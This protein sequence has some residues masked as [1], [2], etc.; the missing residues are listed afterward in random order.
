MRYQGKITGWKDEQGFGFVMPNGGGEKAFVHIKSFSIHQRRPIEGDLITYELAT[1][2]KM[3]FQAKNVQFVAKQSIASTAS[4]S[5]ATFGSIFT[6]LFCSFL[7]LSVLIHK[8]PLVILCIYLSASV[9]TFFAYAIDKS[10]AKNNRWRTRESTLHLFSLI[11]G[12]PGALLAQKKLHHKS[13][14]EE[15]QFIFWVSVIINCFAL[16]W[17]LVNFSTITSNLTLLSGY[18]YF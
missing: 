2:E 6:F 14:K 10:S 16:G 3:R 15:F 11:G 12:W 13:K 7:V 4:Q 8:I 18:A 9:I 1:D 5:K 17:V